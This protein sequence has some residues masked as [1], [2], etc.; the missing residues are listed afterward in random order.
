MRWI[1]SAVSLFLLAVPA[2]ARQKL[3]GYCEDGN[4]TVSTL[5]LPSTNKVQ[6]SFPLCTV[7]VYVTGTTN[8]APIYSDNNGT[9]KSNPFTAAS[10]GAWFFYA[11]NGRYDIR[12]S[13]GGIASPFTRTDF[14][15][16]DPANLGGG[17]VSTAA[18]IGTVAIGQIVA[19]GS[20]NGTT[21]LGGPTYTQTNTASALV[22][23]TSNGSI[24]AQNG[25]F[26][27]SVTAVNLTASGA[28]NAVLIS[29]QQTSDAT[30]AIFSRFSG[31]QSS[32]IVDFGGLS[33]IDKDGNF[34][35]RAATALALASA[36][37]QCSA[38]QVVHLGVSVAGNALGCSA[39][40]LSADVTGNLPVANLG[41]GTG[42]SS[43]TYWRGDG[44]WATPP[45][46]GGGGNVSTS[47]TITVTVGQL[48]AFDATDGTLIKGGPTYASAATPSAL[49]QRDGSG[50]ILGVG[51]VF[52]A[53][54]S[55]GYLSV[56]PAVDATTA[57]F[58]RF[59]AGQTSPI[60]SFA[61]LSLI[62]KDG[63][64]TGNA[65]TAT[66]LAAT[67]TQCSAGQVVHLGIS[68]SGAANGCS[69][70]SLS[71]EVTGNLP[72]ANL[73]SG[74]SASSTT[75]WRGDG[76]WATP[77]GTVTNATTLTSGQLIFGNGGTSVTVGNLS[78]VV[79]TSGSGVTAF[80]AGTTGSGSVVLANSPTMTSPSMLLI[81][82]DGIYGYTSGQPAWLQHN[83]S[84]GTD[85]LYLL[86][87]GGYTF[88][89][90]TV[91]VASANAITGV[92]HLSIAPQGSGDLILPAPLQIRV[93][94]TA[95][96]VNQV[97]AATDTS[98]HLKWM[99]IGSGGTVTSV[100][101]T[102]P[103]TGGTF[104]TSG[105]IAC[106]TCVTSAAA[107]TANALVLGA[108]SQATAAMGSLGT[109]TTVLH[110]N[111]AGAPTFGQVVNADIA[112]GT[113]D[114]T[115][116]LTG[117]VPV[118]NGG[119]GLASLT[120]YAILAGG[121]SGTNP[122][123]QVSG[124]GTS[125]QVLTSNG[126]GALPTW[127]SAAS[128]GGNVSTT[129]PNTSGYIPSW[130]GSTSLA[131]GY[132]TSNNVATPNS[133]LTRSGQGEFLVRDSGGQ[134][135]NIQSLG[136]VDTTGAS[137]SRAAFTSAV[138]SSLSATGGVILIPNGDYLI[139]SLQDNT[140]FPGCGIVVGNGSASSYSTINS[141][142]FKGAGRGAGDDV[143]GSSNANR[144]AT[145]IKAGGSVTK[146]ICVAGPIINVRFEGINFDGQNTADT[147]IYFIQAGGGSG[148]NDVS[149]RQFNGYA[150]DTN[151]VNT[152]AA[153]F[154]CG[155]SFTN[156]DVSEPGSANSGGIRLDGTY[157]G[158][159]SASSC[160]NVVD[161]FGV[162][163]T[164]STTA[165]V[166]LGRADNNVIRAGNADGVTRSTNYWP[167]TAAADNGSGLI[168]ITS[169]Q[170]F[171]SPGGFPAGTYYTNGGQVE[172]KDIV[173]CTGAN[174]V[175]S[176]TNVN[177]GSKLFDL[178]GSDS[179]GCAYSSG[180]KVF[181]GAPALMVQ[182]SP[183]T[184]FPYGNVLDHMASN[185]TTVLRGTSGTNGNWIFNTG[186]EGNSFPSIANV[187]GLGDNGL[188]VLR[189]VSTGDKT[190]K[191][192]DASN[193]EIFSLQRGGA[194]GSGLDI[195]TFDD[196]RF[197]SGGSLAPL[198]AKYF[199]VTPVAVGSLPACNAGRAGSRS[200]VT[201]AL[202][203]V[204][205]ATVAGG[206]S[207]K[208]GVYCDGTNWIVQ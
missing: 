172:I 165:G 13:G 113:I 10:T 51:G 180:G 32:P 45:G 200:G 56:T 133:V 164:G 23:R 8:L 27:G 193:T 105:T 128:G 168:R 206:G 28:V 173:G 148:V 129:G 156:F 96:T 9:V 42:A 81:K 131:N 62:D 18:G 199:Q 114:V 137:D 205:L 142:L 57:T 130:N 80:S 55:S 182:Q 60:V 152:G 163:F 66:A 176:I 127:Q 87:T 16:A 158:G 24:A 144:G 77:P 43:T 68:T 103:I 132:P 85:D 91:S 29:A 166:Y 65:A 82:T 63:K 17:N 76:T 33:T 196:A 94:G 69:A 86:V 52:A 75:F 20:T 162:E 179:T 154:S 89:N 169:S 26:G 104:T 58:N 149:F 44:T 5:S 40:S 1:L 21:I 6:G 185:Y 107:L 71:S 155:N 102:G 198:G 187:R 100:A 121:T 7:T 140:N 64:F 108:G 120:A 34:T 174:G 110:G 95:P 97:L 92:S 181:P 153:F 202:A 190:I 79:T 203:P 84:S 124:L 118:A 67:P 201:D 49:V 47:G 135:V 53:T 98:G 195:Q 186:S 88:G 25:T 207:V 3:Q 175:W 19:F 70:V 143:S 115:A 139:S 14:L 39:V 50:N 151:S 138:T 31:S 204:A 74:T 72:V 111:A 122:M 109:T 197:M 125:G 93:G 147:G 167:V 37:T 189:A 15:L 171:V 36:G 83:Y 54:V 78:G 2:L 106:P 4:I 208:V 191:A 157:S 112:N 170:A 48:T 35:G 119:T 46:A 61:G 116:K 150:I 184:G 126:A 159:T 11:D 99:T 101:T 194:S 73:N 41:S 90:D 177:T 22:Q 192:T 188:L 183:D 134:V 160:S 123:Q 12:F 161:R 38:G 136:G 146:I 30:T 178:V 117:S 145:R 141:V 59:S